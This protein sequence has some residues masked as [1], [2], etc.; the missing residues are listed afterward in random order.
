MLKESSAPLGTRVASSALGPE[1]AAG[2]HL[3]DDSEN[4]MDS[5]AELSHGGLMGTALSKPLATVLA[6]SLG[7]SFPY[8]ISV[9]RL[10]LFTMHA[11]VLDMDGATIWPSCHGTLE[12]V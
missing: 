12:T 9:A 10:S 7:K 2:L 4:L 11:K 3:L 6:F 5:L 8:L 1:A